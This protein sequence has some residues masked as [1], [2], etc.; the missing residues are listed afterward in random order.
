M[1]INSL[2]NPRA[3]NALSILFTGQTIFRMIYFFV[4]LEISQKLIKFTKK[5]ITSYINQN[6]SFS[7][8]FNLKKFLPVEIKF[9]K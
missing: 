8:E 6:K 7:H 2:K 1:E 3:V 9:S 4:S 5:S